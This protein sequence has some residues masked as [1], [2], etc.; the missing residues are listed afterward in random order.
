LGQHGKKIE[1]PVGYDQEIRKLSGK[2]AFKI[3][4]LPNFLLKAVS[5]SPFITG[6]DRLSRAAS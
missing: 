4:I 3:A 1:K 5:R 6:A 2:R